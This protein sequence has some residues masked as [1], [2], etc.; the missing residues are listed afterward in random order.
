MRK[1]ICSSPVAVPFLVQLLDYRG[2][3]PSNNQIIV[4]NAGGI[5]C[6]L[7]AVITHDPSQRARLREAGCYRKLCDHLKTQQTTMMVQNACGILL[8]LSSHCPD[9]QKAMWQLGVPKQ[10]LRLKDLEHKKI[11]EYAGKALSNLL[12]YSQ[13]SM[14]GSSK[15]DI[16]PSKPPMPLPK[17][18]PATGSEIDS[19]THDAQSKAKVMMSRARSLH[20]EVVNKPSKKSEEQK[21][22][23]FAEVERTRNDTHDLTKKKEK[24]R[25]LPPKTF[26]RIS[27]APGQ[28]Q[29]P[30]KQ[31]RLPPATIE[32]VQPVS[33]SQAALHLA[34]KSDDIDE[35]V[36]NAGEDESVIHHNQAD[37]DSDD[38]DTHL[39]HFYVNIPVKSSH[40]KQKSSDLV[41]SNPSRGLDHP[42]QISEGQHAADFAKRGTKEGSPSHSNGVHSSPKME[43]SSKPTKEVGKRKILLGFGRSKDRTTDV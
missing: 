31:T 30:N 18:K 9:D 29:A 12:Q 16:T 22:V 5:L 25:K 3:N 27:S 2:S 43:A 34:A 33:P 8:N 1:S 20:T 10:L 38:E 41:A 6:N 17:D 39:S 4:E 35:M 23:I 14:S 36:S 40:K 21:T 26:Q 7:S 32:E 37:L 28:S 11:A 13:S 24:A 19:S 15:S 42:R